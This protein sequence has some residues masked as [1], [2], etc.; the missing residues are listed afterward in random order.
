V[1]ALL[2]GAGI[3]AATA[4][5]ERYQAGIAFSGRTV[6][7]VAIVVSG[8]GLSIAVVVRTGLGTLPVTLGTIAVAL[9]AAPV[10]G[11]MLGLQSPLRTLIGVGTAICG[12][13]A[14]A[15]VSSVLEPDEAETALAI[16]TV[17][18]YNIVAVLVFPPIGHLLGL[19]QEAF[20]C[21]PGRRSTTRRRSSRPATSTGGTP[22][23]TP[24]S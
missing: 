13:S 8:F 15:A 20:G 7:Q 1:F 21:G 18:F 16:A 22:A 2:L 4:L 3:R 19:S 9:I 10:V 17:F 5:P 23:I 11:R 6:L 24:R 12:A 14:I